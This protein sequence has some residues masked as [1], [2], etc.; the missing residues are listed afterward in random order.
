MPKPTIDLGN[1]LWYE[2]RPEPAGD[3]WIINLGNGLWY[4]VTPDYHS[5][6][7]EGIRKVE[8]SKSCRYVCEWNTLDSNG[9]IN[10]NPV[11]I[12]WNDVPHPQGSNWMALFRGG[13][14][15]GWF[16]RD[17]I[18]ASRLPI[19]AYLSDDGEAVFSKHRHDYRRS[20]DSSI[21]VDGGRDYTRFIG[22]KA[23]GSVWLLPQLGKVTMIDESAARLLLSAFDKKDYDNGYEYDTGRRII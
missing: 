1:G 19:L 2:R 22:K 11:M 10:E 7:L 21:S 13:G 17:G 12:F 9:K 16:V 14:H 15:L 8:E 18:S 5:V 6:T 20:R 23:G 4:D 3:D